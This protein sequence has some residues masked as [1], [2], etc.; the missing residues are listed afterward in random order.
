MADA[1]RAISDGQD[2]V[3]VSDVMRKS[4]HACNLKFVYSHIQPVL[5]VTLATADSNPEPVR[6]SLHRSHA[7]ATYTDITVSNW[8]LS[9]E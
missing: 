8:S 7:D 4:D 1:V 3:S 2:V 5:P 9:D 6:T